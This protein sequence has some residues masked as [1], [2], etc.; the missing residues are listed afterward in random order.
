[1]YY[2]YVSF[3]KKHIDKIINV[4]SCISMVEMIHNNNTHDFILHFSTYF[5]VPIKIIHNH[6]NTNPTS[7]LFSLLP[8]IPLELILERLS[9]LDLHLVRPISVPKVPMSYIEYI[10]ILI[11]DF[12]MRIHV[13]ARVRSF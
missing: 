11:K 9:T 7:I 13:Y 6:R 10:F 4:F 8:I 12:C 5:T 3:V 1:M 2:I